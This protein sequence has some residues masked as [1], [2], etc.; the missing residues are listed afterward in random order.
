VS[1]DHSSDP[2]KRDREPQLPQIG[3]RPTSPFRLLATGIVWIVCG[4]IAL[5]SLSASWKF[6]PAI[7]FIGVGLLWLRGA[8]VT[9][10]RHERRSG[11]Q[12]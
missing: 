7:F 9:L 11:E 12:R 6:I 10:S 8:A 1:R 4:I 3:K 2:R 5:T